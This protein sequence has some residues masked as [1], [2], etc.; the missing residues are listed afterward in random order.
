MVF[1][2]QDK[3]GAKTYKKIRYEGK[4]EVLKILSKTFDQVFDE[5]DSPPSA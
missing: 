4:P 3:D 1:E 2:K 5:K